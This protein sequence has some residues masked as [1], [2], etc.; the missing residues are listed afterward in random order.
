M[1]GLNQHF[2][3]FEINIYTRDMYILRGRAG[4][5]VGFLKIIYTRLALFIVDGN[6][7]IPSMSTVVETRLLNQGELMI[8]NRFKCFWEIQFLLANFWG[9]CMIGSLGFTCDAIVL[10][11]FTCGPKAAF[12]RLFLT[13]ESS[14]WSLLRYLDKGIV[15]KR[16]ANITWQEDRK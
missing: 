14:V 12:G 10:G 4:I 8:E 15:S 13:R 3:L 2:V 16:V 6:K 7:F 5:A 9:N 11:R 1:N